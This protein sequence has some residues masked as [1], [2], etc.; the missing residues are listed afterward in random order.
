MGGGKGGT[1]TS[2]V[3]IP[4]EVLA[5]YNAVNARA[6]EVAKT[7][8]QPYTGQFVA[9]ITPTQQAGI[10]GTSAAA[11]LAQPFYGAGAQY[12]QQG[13]QAVGPLT[14]QQISYYQ[15]PF[16]QAV[17]DPTV[18]AL[19]QEQGQQRAALSARQA[20]TGAFGG[21]RSGLERA[22][23]AR[24][25]GLGMAQAIA[26]LYSQ[27]YQTGVQTATGQQ[28]VI[29]SDLARRLQA[30][31]QIAGLGTGAQAAALQGAQAQ[32]GAG[33]LEQ[34][35]KQADLTAQYQQY[36]QQQGY[37]FQVAQFLAN[38]AMGTGALSG[39]TTTTQQPS[40]FFSD[41]RL[42]H[43]VHE[44]GKT[45][46]GLPIY[47]F[48]YNGDNKTQIGL[49]AQDVEKKHP[50]AVG[51]MGGYKTVDYGK[52]TEDSERPERAYGGS[53]S[54]GGG[55]WHPDAYAGGGLVD[56]D[57]MKSILQAQQAGFGPFAGGLYG[58]S[59][60]GLPGSKATGIVPQASLPV[61]K[62]VTA[63]QPAARQASGLS[64][65][66]QVGSNIASTGR[67][68]V[69]FK[70]WVQ[71]LGKNKPTTGAAEAA[72]TGVTAPATT[73]KADLPSAKARDVSTEPSAEVTGFKVPGV[74]P[75]PQNFDQ[76]TVTPPD[77]T[78]DLEGFFA[79][80]GVI[81]RYH[82]APGGVLPYK[83]AEDFEYIPISVLQE[84]E[85]EADQAA[86][87]FKKNAGAG[88]GGG[89][90][91]GGLG[92]VIGTAANLASIGKFMLPFFL[93]EGGVVPSRGHYD[94][95]GPT[96]VATGVAPSDTVDDYEKQAEDVIQKGLPR[97]K[98]MESRGL[99][100]PN[101]AG[102]SSAFGPYQ[103]L[104]GT[105]A[106]V[107]KRHPEAGV[108]PRDH[109]NPDAQEALAPHYARDLAKA[110]KAADVPFDFNALRMG[111][112][113]GE[114]GGPAFMS[115][116]LRNPDAPSTS[117]VS[118]QVIKANPTWFFN[119]DGTV[120]T[121]Q[122]TIAGLTKGGAGGPS[123]GV[124][125]AQS[126]NR[127]MSIGDAVRAITPES[128]PTSQNFWIP[129]LSG[130]GAMLASNRPTFLGAL[131]EGLVG[132]VAGY[133]Q[134]QK[135][136][137]EIAKQV[138]DVIKERF[139]PFKDK[140]GNPKFMDKTL[141]R[142]VTPNDVM[143]F[144]A[145]YAQ[146]FGFNPE[147]LGFAPQAPEAPSGPTLGGAKRT[148]MTGEP[149]KV[150]PA[151]VTST[152]AQPK[153]QPAA[154]EAPSA[155]QAKAE[156]PNI[157]KMNLAELRVLA[158]TRPDQ[159][160]GLLN[161]PD[162]D[163][164]KMQAEINELNAQADLNINTNPTMSKELKELAEKTQ[165][166]M[167]NYIKD[168]VDLQYK[169]N[170]GLQEA[171]TKDVNDYRAEAV[172][173]INTA[174]ILDQNVQ[175]LADIAADYETGMF[176]EARAKTVQI[177]RALGV[178]RML[179]TNW[180]ND[181]DNYDEAFKLSLKQALQAAVQDKLVRAPKFAIDIEKQAYPG[182]YQS[183]GAM[184][185]LLG[186]V[187]GEIRMHKDEYNSYLQKPLGYDHVKHMLEFD[188][189]QD[190]LRGYTR[191]A[192]ASL[193]AY[194]GVPE[195]K[196]DSLRRTY[197]DFTPKT[198]GAAT[199]APA[200]TEQPSAP[201]LPEPLRGVEGLSY[202]PSRKQYRDG[203]GNIYDLSGKRVQ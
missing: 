41:R 96:P 1:T 191:D 170:V 190:K 87:Q 21:D 5:R 188:P 91:G 185:A 102:A 32:I 31:Q 127:E 116:A 53:A 88:G 13:A 61:P 42:K 180:Q 131:G 79:Q 123:R 9:G 46:D 171:A 23:L 11:G 25:Q 56:A 104:E 168:A 81:P 133:Q 169:K 19:Q 126:S 196:L 84:G 137:A 7:P 27:G 52:A 197:G 94:D 76:P 113:M 189:K 164:R 128:F 103:F 26:P 37:P 67:A 192:Y 43:D 89:G 130:I 92:S 95:G 166:R 145:G 12:T 181:P 54:M 49:M 143:R 132:G 93:A 75:T 38:I 14:K 173:G 161:D 148:A 165:I 107:A 72:K 194:K 18:A 10:T 179:P 156:L 82:K 55:V 117:L 44:I 74:T 139:V 125:T 111:W 176:A 174:K 114:K 129:A 184:Y 110:Y 33:T 178:D 115:A 142:E 177:A 144:G 151:V 69:D 36:L 3:S 120:K 106:D 121:A 48:K 16:T 73:G 135:F 65:A 157:N 30:G 101:Y 159:I 203:A 149:T 6:E 108:D 140:D 172:R 134:Q 118:P 175:R 70:N 105:F 28:G 85:Q 112:A 40:G 152:E 62:L 17:V 186:E 68:A 160:P 202:S 187:L 199:S 90:G 150:A 34:Q 100:V 147:E 58:G 2:T 45:N 119:P 86:G 57:D 182:P 60:Q 195:E 200:G 153:A 193:P 122:E 98:Q 77:A 66:A 109:R 124:S 29:A 201:A 97:V 8:F 35:T 138:M 22:N 155:G 4:P 163:P 59:G 99:N 47:S 64:Q 146:K 83:T 154:G 50:D 141:N 162:N 158:K 136:Q 80:G 24:Q 183:P 20:S 51:V 71:G 39:S 167:D 15:D 198:R 63:A 78:P